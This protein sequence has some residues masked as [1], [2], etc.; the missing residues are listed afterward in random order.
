MQANRI[1]HGIAKVLMQKGV[2]SVL[3]MVVK[4]LV[5]AVRQVS[6]AQNMS[7][8]VQER[9]HNQLRAGCLPSGQLR[10]LQGVLQL[11]N[12]FIGVLF[13]TAGRKRRPNPLYN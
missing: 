12:A 11:S 7:D 9:G 4:V 3:V 6:L 10:T 2:A 8:I 5:A 13:I 1:G